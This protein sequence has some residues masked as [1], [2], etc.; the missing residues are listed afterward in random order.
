MKPGLD[1]IKESIKERDE[2]E[3]R[4]QISLFG[5]R[6]KHVER[7]TAMSWLQSTMQNRNYRT[8][9]AYF[10]GVCFC[11]AQTCFVTT[12]SIWMKKMTCCLK[13]LL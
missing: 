9:N 4:K 5:K 1:Q 8:T 10:K 13:S 7:N 6:D 2:H 12:I 11:P 3:N